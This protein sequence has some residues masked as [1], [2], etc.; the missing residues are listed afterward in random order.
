MPSIPYNKS[1]NQKG[2]WTKD[3]SLLKKYNSTR[4]RKA[5]RH[6]LKNSPLCS[7]CE[8]NG[9]STLAKVVDHKI[10]VSQGGDFWEPKNHNS[11]CTSCHN[12]KSAAESNK[13]N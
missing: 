12:S 9:K 3:K 5:R 11:L 1:K 6:Q 8:N 10:P 4:W 7:E 2:P 13:K